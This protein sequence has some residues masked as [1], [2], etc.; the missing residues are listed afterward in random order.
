MTNFRQFYDTEQI[1]FAHSKEHEVVTVIQGE[2]GRGKTA[3]YRAMMFAL[4]GDTRLEQDEH[5]SDIVLANIKAIEEQALINQGINS[6]VTLWFTHQDQDYKITRTYFSIKELDGKIREELHAVQLVNE[7]THHEWHTE[8]EIELEIMMIIDPRVKHYFFFDGERI[9]RLTRVSPQQKEEVATGIKNLLKIDQILKSKDVLKKLLHQVKKDLQKHS[10]GELRIVLKELEQLDTEEGQLQLAYNQLLS[11]Q[12]RNEH[13]VYEIEK[14]LEQFETMKKDIDERRSI[15]TSLEELTTHIDAEFQE[16]R[17]VNKYLPLLM[18]EDLL[19]QQM[20]MIS[21]E[22]LDKNF[23]GINAEFV[24]ELIDNMF[25]ICGS[26]ME[27]G[28]RRH[29]ELKKLEQQL[30]SFEAKKDIHQLYQGIQIIISY[31]EER[32]DFIIKTKDG[33]ERL[34]NQKERLQWELEQLNKKIGTVNTDEIKQLNAERTQH[35]EEITTIKL[36]MKENQQTQE[37]VSMKKIKLNSSR[38]ELEKKSGIHQV[39]I[40]KHSILEQAT[41]SMEHIIR[42]FEADLI[43]DLQLATQQNLMY[44]L[45]KAGQDMIKRV[46]V[47]KDY[48][49][50]VLNAYEQPFLANI[51]QGQR[52]V[53]SLSFITALAQVASGSNMM[54][55]PLFMDTP[56]GRISSQHQQNLLEYL[57][58]ISSQWVLLVTDREFGHNE[59]VQFE[60]TGIIGTYYRLESIG[61]GETRIMK[62]QEGAVLHG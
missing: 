15:E 4:F 48:S 42:Q 7:T 5:S 39:L 29:Q 38:K 10:T 57:P 56:F 26:Q 22:L 19:L 53:L 51:S 55:M 25:C 18:S 9:E 1:E 6:S 12:K 52:Q 50:E 24:A 58:K 21:T 30:R 35:Q 46:K 11:N 16:A 28:D 23:M 34:M 44:L 40:K 13:A 20:T 45:D 31:L 43:E 27:E 41:K 17:K 8:N 61:A 60:E 59:K 37:T 32:Q 3:I 36:Q 33:I 49:L 54:E 62:V 47:E 2:N 14:Q